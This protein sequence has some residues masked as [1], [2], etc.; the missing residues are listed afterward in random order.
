MKTLLIIITI[1][2]STIILFTQTRS[3]EIGIE[4]MKEDIENLSQIKTIEA[5]KIPAV[6]LRYM[7]FLVYVGG[8]YEVNPAFISKIVWCESRWD[9]DAENPESSA[10]GL[11]QITD[12]TW[13]EVMERMEIEVS[14]GI[15]QFDWNLNLEAMAFLISQD[16][17]WRWDET[18]WCWED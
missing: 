14:D 12:E 13:I 18:K 16:E 17:L 5:Q 6:P 8:R 15:D 1:V 4:D 7:S 11:G 10:R 2:L 3:I 9:P